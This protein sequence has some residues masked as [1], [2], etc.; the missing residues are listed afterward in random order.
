ML[1]RLLQIIG[2]TASAFGVGLQGM[3]LSGAVGFKVQIAA[4][5]CTAVGAGC[6]LGAPKMLGAKPGADAK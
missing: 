1:D 6:A 5:A 3:N 2:V 4:I